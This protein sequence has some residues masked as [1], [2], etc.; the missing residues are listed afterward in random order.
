MDF[1]GPI[2]RILRTTSLV[3][4]TLICHLFLCAIVILGVYGIEEMIH[5]LWGVEDPKFFDLVPLRY[6]FGAADLALTGVLA[7]YGIADAIDIFRGRE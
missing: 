5:N 4:L 1:W 6:V 3:G 7:G 2:Y